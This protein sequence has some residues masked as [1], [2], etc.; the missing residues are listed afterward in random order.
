M[1]EGD[2]CDYAFI[3]SLTKEEARRALVYLAGYS[4]EDFARLRE[5]IAETREKRRKAR[6]GMQP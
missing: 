3:D 6:G 5:F 1:T 4:P 2:Q